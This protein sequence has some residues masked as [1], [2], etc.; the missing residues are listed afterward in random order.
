M[1]SRLSIFQKMLITPLI[2]LLL[3]ASYMVFVYVHQQANR[4]LLSQVQ[5]IDFPVIQLANENLIL[6]DSIVNSFKDAVGAKEETWLES[7]KKARRQIMRDG[8]ADPPSDNNDLLHA[9][10]P[11]DT[12]PGR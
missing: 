8:A 11:P 4:D 1:I 2:G 9:I 7:A 5:G 12:F 10:S 6:F 3:F